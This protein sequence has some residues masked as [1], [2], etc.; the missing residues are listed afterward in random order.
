VERALDRLQPGDVVLVGRRN[1]RMVVIAHAGQKGQKGQ[2]G[3]GGG[4]GRVLAVDPGRDVRRLGPDDFGTPPESVAH[5]ELPE[6]YAPRSPAFRR[7]VADAGRAALVRTGNGNTAPSPRETAR[8]RSDDRRAAG[9]SALSRQEREVQ[10]LERRVR[11]RSESLARQFDRVL[12]LLESWGYVEEWELTDAGRL[13]ARLSHECDLLLAEA[14]RDRVFQNLAASELAAAVSCFTYEKRGPDDARGGAHVRWPSNGVAATVR[15][16][17]RRWRDLNAAEDDHRLPATRP[18][19]PGFVDAMFEWARGDT[20]ALVLDDEL[21]AG[22]F[23]R[24]VKQCVDV[25]RQVADVDPD[26]AVAA[27][28]RDAARACLRGV[29]AAASAV[30]S[31]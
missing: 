14:I 26:P 3:R 11:A 20:L 25:L 29:V 13:L 19:D 23:V 7:M 9:A 5:V 6:P 31:A 21:S 2:K 17:E 28:A 1:T 24:Q 8:D 22:D 12:G 16:I 18:V 4:S 15:S 30:G 10:R 27:T